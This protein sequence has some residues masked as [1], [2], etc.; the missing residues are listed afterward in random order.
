LMRLVESGRVDLTPLITHVFSL[1][2]IGKAYELFGSRGENVL[3]I[4]I[5]VS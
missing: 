4:A 5:R 1:D 3:K 2:D